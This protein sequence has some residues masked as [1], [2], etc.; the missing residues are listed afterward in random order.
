MALSEFVCPSEEGDYPLLLGV[1]Q[2]VI[3]RL[4]SSML[5]HVLVTVSKAGHS[6]D[7]YGALLARGRQVLPRTQFEIAG[8]VLG[9]KC[10]WSMSG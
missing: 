7:S 5:Y 9:R 8:T 4:L 10:I 2:S 3:L 1:V 6:P